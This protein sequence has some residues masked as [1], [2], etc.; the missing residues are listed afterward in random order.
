MGIIPSRN[1]DEQR[2][3]QSGVVY[4]DRGVISGS[5]NR[6]YSRFAIQTHFVQRRESKEDLVKRYVLPLYTP[7]DVLAFGAKVMAMCADSVVERKD[8]KPGFWANFLWRF[9]GINHTGVGMHEPYKLQLVINIVGLPRVLLAAFLS[10]ITRPFGVHGVFY[11]VCGQ[12]VGGID[13]FYFRSSFDIYK[14]LA[15]INPPEPDRLCDEVEESTGIPTVLMDAN[16]L[17]RDQLG[18]SRGVPLTDGELQ[19]ALRDNPSG[20]GDELTPLILIKPL[21]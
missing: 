21:N 4:F 19:D 18:R 6:R 9:A 20:Q 3:D 12:G 11:K 15:L 1:L 2:R 10:A 5:N 17:Q 8:V 13:G 14:E 16:D 7:G